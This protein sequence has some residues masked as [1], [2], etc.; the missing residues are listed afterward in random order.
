MDEDEIDLI[1]DDIRDR[2]P[3]GWGLCLILVQ[4]AEVSTIHYRSNVERN[5]MIQVLTRF[6]KGAAQ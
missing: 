3:E 6:I 1:A 4:P 2:I 5:N